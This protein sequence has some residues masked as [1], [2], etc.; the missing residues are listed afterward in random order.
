MRYK[1]AGVALAA[2]GTYGLWLGVL[3]ALPFFQVKNVTITG[4]SGNAAP[5][6]AGTLERTAREMDTTDFSTTRLRESV[7]AYNAVAG[8][9][10]ATEFPQGVRITVVERTP[11]ARLTMGSSTLRRSR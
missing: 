3:R 9:R 8:L 1:L 10:V 2:L 7:A 6:I 4:L 5:Q 11:I